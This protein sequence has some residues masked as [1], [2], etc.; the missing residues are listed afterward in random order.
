MSIRRNIK[1]VDLSSA[2]YFSAG[3]SC[4]RY[5]YDSIL[6]NKESLKVYCRWGNGSGELHFTFYRLCIFPGFSFC[7]D[8]FLEG[9]ARLARFS[10]HWSQGLDY[11][12]FNIDEYILRTCVHVCVTEEIHD[13]TSFHFTNFGEFYEVQKR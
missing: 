7:R 5:H 8:P 9:S 10:T 4:S 2:T 12:A 13:L 11:S 1:R 6:N 3:L